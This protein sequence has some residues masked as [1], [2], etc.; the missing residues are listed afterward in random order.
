MV[1]HIWH[2][3]RANRDYTHRYQVPHAPLAAAYSLALRLS[4]TTVPSQILLNNKYDPVHDV[5]VN[6]DGV[7]AW[8]TEKP[9]LHHQVTLARVL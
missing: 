9:R 2:G 3:D 6:E 4:T 1:V 5:R 8:S 7:L